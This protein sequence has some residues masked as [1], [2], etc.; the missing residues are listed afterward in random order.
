MRKNMNRK[1][2]VDTDIVLDVITRREPFYVPA[3]QVFSLAAEKKIE[4][5]ISPVL[6]ANLFYI[7]RKRIGKES[8]I[9][10][11]RKLRIL[12]K[13]APVD[14]EIVD[15]VLS[16]GFKDMEDGFQYYSALKAGIPVLLTRNEKDFV[17]MEIA[18]MNCEEYLSA[19]GMKTKRR[20]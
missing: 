20:R 4:L 12:A 17:G 8:A 3:A 15:L 1:V 5:Y 11:I 2:F 9:N 19:Y 18:I 6:I 16:S 10:A 7:L 14:E 13:V